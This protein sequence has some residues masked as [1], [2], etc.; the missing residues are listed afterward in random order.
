MD[1]IASARAFLK[2]FG[3]Q[4]AAISD[5]AT[6]EQNVDSMEDHQVMM[7]AMRAGWRPS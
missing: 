6:V 4:G 1:D 2:N 7:M 5:H 3:K